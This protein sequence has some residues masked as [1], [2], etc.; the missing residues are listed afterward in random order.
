MIVKFNK[1]LVN[2]GQNV[3]LWIIWIIMVAYKYMYKTIHCPYIEKI[4]E[5]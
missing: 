1:Y 5:K 3:Q 2:Y 4:H